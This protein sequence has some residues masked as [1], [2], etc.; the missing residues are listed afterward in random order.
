[1][2]SIA[3]GGGSVGETDPWLFVDGGN[4]NQGTSREGQGGANPGCEAV[5]VDL[6]DEVEVH[7]E[8]TSGWTRR[9]VRLDLCWS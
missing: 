9:Y 4:A 7:S 2:R 3:G 6:G 8:A 1:M 5:S